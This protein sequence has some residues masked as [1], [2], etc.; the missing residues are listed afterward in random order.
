MSLTIGVAGKGGVG[1]TTLSGLL[2]RHMVATDHKPVLAID[3]D[4]NANLNEVLNLKVTDTLGKTSEEM[5]KGEVPTGMGKHDYLSLR[6]EQCLV[7]SKGMDLLVMGRPE[8]PG[9][10]CFANNI[11]RDVINRIGDQY[12]Y[13]VI[14]NEAGLE[15]LSRR[16]MRHIDH[17]LVV[18]DP[19]VRGLQAAGRVNDLI[20]E[21]GLR[22]GKVSLV[23]TRVHGDLPAALDGPIKATGIELLGTVAEDPV[24]RQF[25]SE[26]RPL[27]ELPEDGPTVKAVA[28]I[29]AAI[30]IDGNK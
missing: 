15:H 11:L 20:K 29:A 7:E 4:P 12:P 27:L 9:C 5:V 22:V 10:Y 2:I 23:I 18:S 24:I 16:I 6:A 17:L 19:T 30:G 3:A 1:K 8:G 13:L 14:D 25:D 21:L 26:G 28:Q